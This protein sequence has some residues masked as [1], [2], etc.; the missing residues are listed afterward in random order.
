MSLLKGEEE[1]SAALLVVGALVEDQSR[2]DGRLS[3][4]I[5]RD[6]PNQMLMHLSL[7]DENEDMY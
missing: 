6:E 5:A 2:G 4:G 1:N 3:S 7:S